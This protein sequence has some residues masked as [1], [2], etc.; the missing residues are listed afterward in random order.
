M[1]TGIINIPQPYPNNAAR[2]FKFPVRPD[3]SV[4]VS[5]FYRDHRESRLRDELFMDKEIKGVIFKRAWMLKRKLLAF[6]RKTKEVESP[7]TLNPKT[8]PQIY[9]LAGLLSRSVN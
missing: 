7:K 8:L 5:S 4:G 2:G 3:F 6:G 1:K 9:Q